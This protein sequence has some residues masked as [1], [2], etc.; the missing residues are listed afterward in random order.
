MTFYRILT[1]KYSMEGSANMTFKS[2]I[3]QELVEN[4]VYTSHQLKLFITI[5]DVKVMCKDAVQF[6]QNDLKY[7]VTKIIK[8]NLESSLIDYTIIQGKEEKVYV[9]EKV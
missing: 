2:E 6:I 1:V 4:K 7:R 3:P 9:V 8:G 5:N